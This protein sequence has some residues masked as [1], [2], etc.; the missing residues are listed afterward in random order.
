MSLPLYWNKD[1]KNGLFIEMNEFL[2]KNYIHITLKQYDPDGDFWYR[3]KGLTVTEEYLDFIIEGLE[4]IQPL[5]AKIN[6]PDK[7][8]LEFNFEEK[9]KN[10]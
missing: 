10:E 4:K 6:L 1:K 2:G 8:Q 7:S 3:I 5:L 9:T